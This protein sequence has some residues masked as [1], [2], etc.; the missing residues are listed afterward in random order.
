M[1]NLSYFYHIGNRSLHHPSQ[2]RN[3]AAS[4]E[5]IL[6]ARK[7]AGEAVKIRAGWED[8]ARAHAAQ[9]AV[10]GEPRKKFFRSWEV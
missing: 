5:V 4:Q 7:D 2:R 3:A 8:A 9:K 6:D 10:V 1:I